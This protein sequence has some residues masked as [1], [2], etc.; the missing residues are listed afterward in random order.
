MHALPPSQHIPFVFFAN[1]LASMGIWRAVWHRRGRK[2]FFWMMIGHRKQEVPHEE[3]LCGPWFLLYLG[4][5]GADLGERG[6]GGRVESLCSQL[7]IDAVMQEKHPLFR[8]QQGI[9]LSIDIIGVFSI[10]IG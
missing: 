4:V 7:L 6:V 5:H 3:K 2:G 10:V 9:H 8:I 1:I